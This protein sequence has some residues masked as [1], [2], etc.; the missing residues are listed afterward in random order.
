MMRITF[1]VCGRFHAFPLAIEMEKLGVLEQIYCA[2]KTWRTPR[3]IPASRFQ[4]RWDLAI[5]QRVSRYIPRFPSSIG[6]SKLSLIYGF[7]IEFV[8]F[9]PEFS[10]V[11]I[12]M[13]GERSGR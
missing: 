13:C 4:N 6:T 1:A 9:S 8:I 12:C 11:G 2:D 10:T 5:R 7:S 3:G